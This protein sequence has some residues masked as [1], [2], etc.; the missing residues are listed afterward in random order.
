VALF[1]ESVAR[2]IVAVPRTEEVRFNDMCT[3]RHYPAVRVGVVTGDALDV[4]ELFTIPVDELRAAHRATI[5]A[6]FR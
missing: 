1:S 5:P 3:A 4:Q 2:A 6:L